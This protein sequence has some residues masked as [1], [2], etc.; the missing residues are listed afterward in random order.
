MPAGQKVNKMPIKVNVIGGDT[1]FIAAL[2][3]L[4]LENPERNG[5]IYE[6]WTSSVKDFP[7][8]IDQKVWQLVHS[9]LD[10]SF[11]LL[12]IKTLSDF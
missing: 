5:E 1:T 10:L 2:S 7:E 8:V 3:L 9:W 6:N 11:S 12:N 4:D